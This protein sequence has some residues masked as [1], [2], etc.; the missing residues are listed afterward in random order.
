M[1]VRLCN[2]FKNFG[3][4]CSDKSKDRFF[5]LSFKKLKWTSC[6]FLKKSLKRFKYRFVDVVVQ[7]VENV[8]L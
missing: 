3:L 4:S 8:F 7:A 6:E 2:T 1:F 5:K